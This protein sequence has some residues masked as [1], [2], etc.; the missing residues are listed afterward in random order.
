MPEPRIILLEV[1]FAEKDVAKQLGARWNP[2]IKKW[3]VP[4]GLDPAPFATWCP[5]QSDLP[6]PEVRADAPEDSTES[7]GITLSRYLQQISLAL[8]KSIP[9]SQWVRVEISQIKRTAGGHY[10]LELVEHDSSGQL[11]ARLSGF[12]WQQKAERVIA[13]FEQETGATLVAG[14]K[15]LFQLSVDH[16]PTYGIRALV[17][18]ID[19]AYTLGDIAKKLEAIRKSLIDAQ[20]FDLNRRLPKPMEFTH[21]AVISPKDAAGLGDFREDADRLEAFGVCRFTYYT[22]VFQGPEAASSIRSAIAEFNAKQAGSDSADALCVIRGGGSVTDLYWLNDRD[23][24]EAL[25]RIPI[26]VLTGIGH[27]RDNT[28]LD[29]I[30]NMRFDT[31]SKVIAHIGGTIYANAGEALQNIL[32]ILRLS[33]GVL[34][35]AESEIDRTTLEIMN[36]V[37]HGLTQTELALDKTWSSI[38]ENSQEGIQAS[39]HGLERLI[40]GIRASAD[41]LILNQTAEVNQWLARTLELA[42]LRLDEAS[43]EIEALARE[44]LG[45]GPD[46]TLKRG[47]AMVRDPR[48]KPLTS[49][50]QALREKRLALEFHDGVLGVV[51]DSHGD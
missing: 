8:A 4:E 45:V 13:R 34:K 39:L 20:V 47:F 36:S 3:Y 29:E 38:R 21:V 28:I 33:E 41:S 18:D 24:A 15:A 44:I 22:A 23:L 35:T 17:E 10:Q 46:A 50:R 11:T 31:P 16:S 37:R 30:A 14:I 6:P 43:H 1:P 40:D 9:K 49:R 19:P 7:Q 25:C 5:E 32:I 2:V 26:P 12:L 42:E 27:E 48:G 51:P